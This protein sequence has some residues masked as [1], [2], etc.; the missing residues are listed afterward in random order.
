MIG[1][2]LLDRY[3]AKTVLG[4]IA[5]VTLMLAGLQLF[6]LFV[7]QL[8]DLGKAHYGIFQALLFVILQMPYQVYLFFPMASLLGSLIGL[9]IMAS[10][11]ELVVMR[12]AGMSIGQVT[13]AVLKA[14]LVLIVIVTVA[15]ETLIPRLAHFANDQK[16]QAM[17]EG[18]ASRTSQGIW[19]RHQNDFIAIQTILPNNELRQ[20]YQF[21]FDE[22]HHMRLARKIEKIKY[23]QGTWSAYGIAESVFMNGRTKAENYA[24]MPWDVPLKPNILNMSKNESDEM[25]LHELR[26]YMRAQKMS[27]QSI[28]TYKLA[29]WQRLIQPITT[30]VMMLLAIPFIFGPLRSSTMGSKLLAGATVGFGFNILNRFCGPV[31]QV[32]QWPAE[33][34][35]LGPT[36]LFSLLG[37]YLMRRIR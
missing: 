28:F 21:R 29:Y 23:E 16:L 22:K 36:I 15:S 13:L 11:Y 25:T 17:S 18:H 14:A 35:A 10:H 37:I 1:I 30:M 2:K 9:G 8:D 34:A 7:N 33:V 12:A 20:I 4:A 27:H 24:E 5:L 32:L 19:L 26:Q 6:I 31:S 3:I